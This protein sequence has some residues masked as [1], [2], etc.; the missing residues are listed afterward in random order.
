MQNL[1]IPQSDMPQRSSVDISLEMQE[2]TN[3][4]KLHKLNG[5]LD[6]ALLREES[7]RHLTKVRR[8]E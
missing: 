8:I 1:K 2:E 5:E 7:E 3:V 4:A 6:A